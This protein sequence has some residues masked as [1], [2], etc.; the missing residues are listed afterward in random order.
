M[1]AANI[2]REGWAPEVWLTHPPLDAVT[3]MKG[4]GIGFQEEVYYNTQ[5]LEKLG[6]P[7]NAIRVLP[8][9]VRNTADEERAVAEE[10][11]KVGGNRVIIV[12]A[13]PQSRR[14][15]AMW[16][17]VTGGTAELVVRGAPEEPYDPAHWWRNTRDVE[18]VS[19]EVLGLINFWC[20]FL[21]R[22]DRS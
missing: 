22:P 20:G 9:E 5:V 10:L 7:A 21:A 4:L 18:S 12:A 15:R 17:A 13:R 2:Y 6:I 19:H 11:R 3:A 14:T 8:E 16:H 1:E